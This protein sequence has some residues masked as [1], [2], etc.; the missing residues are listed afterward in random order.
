MDEEAMIEHLQSNDNR[1]SNKQLLNQIVCI[2]ADQG[3][4]QQH[5]IEIEEYNEEQLEE[6]EEDEV[7]GMKLKKDTS[8]M[9]L[10]STGEISH[11]HKSLTASHSSPHT[12][13]DERFLLSCLPILQ[14]LPNKKNALARLKIQQLLF[15]IEFSD[16]NSS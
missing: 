3:D 6:T 12:D 7:E 8:E 4:F 13:P 1:V 2:N 5:H 15:D 14:R 9:V 10:F 11:Q 16:S